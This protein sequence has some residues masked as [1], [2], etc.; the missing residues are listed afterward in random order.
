MRTQEF[1]GHFAVLGTA[2][3]IVKD[4]PLAHLAKKRTDAPSRRP[5]LGG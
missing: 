2:L 1:A 3:K 4:R 5:A